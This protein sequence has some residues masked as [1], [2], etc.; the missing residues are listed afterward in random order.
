[1][2]SNRA[3]LEQHLARA[4]PFTVHADREG[5]Y[6]VVFPDLPG[7][8]TQVDTLGEIGPMADEARQ[9]WIESEYERGNSIPEPTVQEELSGKFVV[10]IPRSLHRSLAEGAARE[11]VSLNHYVCTILARGDVQ[12]RVETKLDAIR[13]EVD[14]LLSTGYAAAG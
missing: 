13:A 8:M 9:L 3:T 1:M 4:Y 12:T 11:N 10:R 6:V 14:A 7:C 2:A 5:G